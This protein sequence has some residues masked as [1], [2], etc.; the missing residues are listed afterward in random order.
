ME[1][2]WVRM[3]A[4][5]TTREVRAELPGYAYTTI[6]TVLDRL[7]RKGEVRRRSVGQVL[8]FTATGSG[9]LHAAR[10]IR[11]A[12]DASD[13]PAAALRRLADVLTPEEAR[14]MREGLD[15][16]SPL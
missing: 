7:A 2:L 9:A 5:L 12:L 6:A 4:E 8:T 15:R 16:R 3:G 1:V 14:A 10:A 11:S 13:D